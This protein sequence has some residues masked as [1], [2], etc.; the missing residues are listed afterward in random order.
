VYF[1]TLSADEAAGVL[2]VKI[3]ASVPIAHGDGQANGSRDALFAKVLGYL[4]GPTPQQPVADVLFT[5]AEKRP[6]NRCDLVTPAML[7]EAISAARDRCL[8]RSR[9]AGRL[10]GLS[11][12]DIVQFLHR[13]FGHLAQTLRP[14]NVA[15]H[16]PEWFAEQSLQ[17]VNV[18][19][20]L[21]RARRPASLGMV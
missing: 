5:S 7:E 19:P 18:V 9:Q 11:A 17:I 3:P 10:L 4:Y 13:Q 2:E 1:C 14:H 6:L 21:R 15:A 20:L 12:N 8:M 16:C